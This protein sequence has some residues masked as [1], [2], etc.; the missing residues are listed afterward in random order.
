MASNHYACAPVGECE[1]CPED[2]VSYPYCR[3]YNN[4]QAVKCTLLGA[5]GAPAAGA[6]DV[7]GWS[8]CGK[9]VGSEMH[10]YALFILGNV[11]LVL[12]A[13]GVYVWR[14]QY[15]TRKYRGML[16][17]RVH[18]RQERQARASAS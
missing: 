2:H 11:V 6:A 15:Q 18:G 4:R 16:Y 13:V 7:Q 14:Q 17:Q 9:F 12:L 3:P 8:A 5:N 1:P 10:Q